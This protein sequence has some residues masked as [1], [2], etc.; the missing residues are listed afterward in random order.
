MNANAETTLTSTTSFYFAGF[1]K[2]D[3]NEFLK[4]SGLPI[5]RAKK[6]LYYWRLESAR[7]VL[8]PAKINEKIK[9]YEKKI[10][11]LRLNL[12]DAEDCFF[13]CLQNKDSAPF[14]KYSIHW[15]GLSD[16][17]DEKVLA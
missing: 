11:F 15:K 4:L 9:E 17:L 1:T 8:A 7:G 14:K 2:N 5:D 12:F 13:E 10:R 3:D 16:F 6:R